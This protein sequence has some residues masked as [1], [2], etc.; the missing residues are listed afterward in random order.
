MNDKPR[1]IAW[2]GGQYPVD[3]Q[4]KVEVLLRC[5]VTAR[6]IASGFCWLM[7]SLSKSPGAAYDIIAYRVIED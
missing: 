1:F 2:Y 6:G 5:G 7:S 4:A 3:R